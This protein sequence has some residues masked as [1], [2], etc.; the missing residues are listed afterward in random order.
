M[1]NLV[2][3]ARARARFQPQSLNQLIK[4]LEEQVSQNHIVMSLLQ[5][6]PGMVVQGQELP[7]PPVSIL[8]LMGTTKR[9]T[10]KN[11]LTR[12]RIL[13]RKD[14]PTQYIVSGCTVL[15]L[16]VNHSDRGVDV[17][18]DDVAAEPIQGES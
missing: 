18:A 8:S 17:D 9:Y 3:A 6:K 14:V 2:E 11:S 13:V 15:E 12:G 7:S 10:G 16:T 1:T 5:L 4:L